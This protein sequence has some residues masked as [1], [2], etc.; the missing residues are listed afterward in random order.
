MGV[1]TTLLLLS[2]KRPSKVTFLK[3]HLYCRPADIYTDQ[4]LNYDQLFRQLKNKAIVSVKFYF[5]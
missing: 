2:D 4:P 1:T 5:H 3:R